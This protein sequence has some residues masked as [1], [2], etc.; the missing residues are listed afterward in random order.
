MTCIAGLVHEGQVWLA[1]DAQSTWG[2]KKKDCGS[3]V[4][5]IGDLGIAFTGYAAASVTVKNRLT[6]PDIPEDEAK[7]DRWLYVE[8]P[9]AIKQCLTDAGILKSESGRIDA[10]VYAIMGW[11]G[12]LCQMDSFLAPYPEMRSYTASGSGGEVALGSLFS[13]ED[14][15]PEERLKTAIQA[16]NMW[17]VGCGVDVHIVNVG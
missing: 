17:S 13:T 5:Q 8:V 15:E 6:L 2:Y 4:L 1:S 3:K 12:R 7:H 14:K 9:D 10:G 11:R 16:A